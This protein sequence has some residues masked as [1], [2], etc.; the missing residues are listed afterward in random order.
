MLMCD[1][2]KVTTLFA[3]LL[4][5]SLQ[6]GLC[7]RYAR[8]LPGLQGTYQSRSSR[9][10]QESEERVALASEARSRGLS[11]AKVKTPAS[12]VMRTPLVSDKSQRTKGRK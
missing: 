2:T 4:L 5:S 10:R 3:V 6:A 8:R 7:S 9:E 1:L 12:G 11:Y